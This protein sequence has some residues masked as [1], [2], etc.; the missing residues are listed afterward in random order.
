MELKQ[1]KA[2]SNKC[3]LINV[4]I[5]LKPDDTRLIDPICTFSKD[6]SMSDINKDLTENEK[7]ERVLSDT[8]YAKKEI[9][10][11][12]NNNFLNR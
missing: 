8:N 1:V 2:C 9:L 6:L 3:K 7:I 11:E 10:G 12:K 5:S 4:D